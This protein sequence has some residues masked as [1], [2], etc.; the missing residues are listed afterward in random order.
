MPAEL[1]DDELELTSAEAAAFLEDEEDRAGS[2]Q[3][4][5]KRSRKDPNPMTDGDLAF[6]RKKFPFLAELSDN[7]VRSQ[8]TGE[9][10]KW[11]Q[12]R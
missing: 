1:S 10:L 9:L 6:L 3:A 12:Q 7:F 11:S 5:A 4:E 2:R 8:T